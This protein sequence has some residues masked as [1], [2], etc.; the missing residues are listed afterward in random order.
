MTL[1]YVVFDT[2]TGDQLTKGM[3]P[4]GY[5]NTIM[6]GLPAGTDVLVAPGEATLQPETDIAMIRQYC[7]AQVDRAADAAC[8]P[9]LTPGDTQAL[10]YRKK[11]DEAERW[12]DE[13]DPADFPFLREEAGATAITIT[14]LA[15]RVIAASIVDDERIARIEARRIATKQRIRGAGQNLAVIKMAMNVDWTS[16][17][18]GE[19]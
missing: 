2:H 9:Y 16:L 5:L 11:L 13:S 19:A 14:Q 8:A 4:E 12:T 15:A 1:H 3:C 18:E 6:N 7:C 10:R 17:A